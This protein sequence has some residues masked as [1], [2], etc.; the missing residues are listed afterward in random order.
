VKLI[1]KWNELECKGES[2]LSQERYSDPASNNCIY[3]LYV[4]IQSHIDMGASSLTFRPECIFSA[5]SSSSSF[6]PF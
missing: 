1:L 5:R 6:S 2:H 3:V 4:I